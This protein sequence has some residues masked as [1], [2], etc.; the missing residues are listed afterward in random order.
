MPYLDLV[1]GLLDVYEDLVEILLMLQVFLKQ[2]ALPNILILKVEKKHANINFV[3]KKTL[4]L[5]PHGPH[6]IH[7]I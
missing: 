5:N 2:A 4:L 3:V 7:G 6:T 1:K